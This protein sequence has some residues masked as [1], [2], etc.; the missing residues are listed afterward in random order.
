M[1]AR[2]AT[3][4]AACSPVAS[5]KWPRWLMPSWVSQPWVVVCRAQESYLRAGV[6]VGEPLSEP[7]VARVDF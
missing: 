4:R 3:A 5:A 6:T 2:S 1:R 7:V